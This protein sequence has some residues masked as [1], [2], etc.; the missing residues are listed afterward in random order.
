MPEE[1]QYLQSQDMGKV[2]FLQDLIRGVKKII[3]VGA[4]TVTQTV[5]TT[6]VIV[7]TM[8]KRASAAIEAGDWEKASRCYDNVLDYDDK[9]EQA[10]VGRILIDFQAKTLEELE[11][12][13]RPLSGNKNYQYLLEHGRR[14]TAAK[15]QGIEDRG[16]VACRLWRE[17]EISREN[18]NSILDIQ[19]V[20][21]DKDVES[22]IDGMREFGIDRFTFS[23]GWSSAVETAWLFKQ[24]GC[25]LEGLVEVNGNM[26]FFEGKHETRHGYLFRVN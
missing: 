18:E 4:V 6:S 16:G 11:N 15:M 1:F 3:D 17:Y 7:E 21:W 25:E 14:E 10:F 2:G 26:N 20:V 23:S 9:N 19:D 13:G 12:G 22:L 8:L 5:G 24:N